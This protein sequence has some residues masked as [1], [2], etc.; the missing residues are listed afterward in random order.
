V[1]S[2]QSSRNLNRKLALGFLL[3]TIIS[4]SSYRPST[5]AA[6][7][8]QIVSGS[9]QVRLSSN[10]GLSEYTIQYQYP[11]VVDLGQNLNLTVTVFVNQLTELKLY[12][13]DWGIVSTISTPNG[14]PVTQK[15]T[16]SNVNDYLYTGSHWGPTTVTIPIN[17]SNFSPAAGQSFVA[18]ISLEWIADVQ[19]DKPYSYHFYENNFTDLGNVTITNNVQHGGSNITTYYYLVI[20]VI[21]IGAIV[22]TGWFL[23]RKRASKR[24]IA[25]PT[26]NN[27]LQISC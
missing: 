21:V 25:S 7:G 6:N 5:W 9:Y 2:L 22:I 4:V 12:V 27:K 17:S 11:S 23:S 26:A 3:A 14:A 1:Q 8:V 16:V 18:S 19:Y 15:I 13:F 10:L 24:A 20:G